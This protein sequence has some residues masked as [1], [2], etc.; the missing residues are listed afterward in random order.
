M[1]D[2]QPEE[3]LGDPVTEEAT[4]WVRPIASR[5]VAVL[6]EL[7]AIGK[8]EKAPANMG[9]YAF[10]GIANIVAELKPLFAKHGVF[11]IP[12]TLD[13][14]DSERSVGNAKIMFVTDVLVQWT[15][16][17]E[18]GDTLNCSTWGQGTDMGDKAPQKAYTAAFKSMLGEVFC[19]A[20][21]DTDS[22]RHDVPETQGDWF[23]A[24]GWD[25]GKE[26]H[27]GTRRVLFDE[28]AGLPEDV[29]LDFKKNFDVTKGWTH[30]QYLE[31][32]AWLSSP[33]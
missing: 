21:S 26:D 4:I 13:R 9:G 15:F 28:V 17:G 22:E 16:I 23:V 31:A 3:D 25:G 14:K 33:K 7:P 8:T 11:V 5:M 20:D 12:V 6:A 30:D 27:D 10:R 18:G 32:E 24:N 29:R 2:G 19:I 1:D